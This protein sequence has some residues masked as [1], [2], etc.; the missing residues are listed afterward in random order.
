MNATFDTIHLAA[1]YDQIQTL[2]TELEHLAFTKGLAP[3]R[4]VN[5]S[6]NRPH[7]PQVLFDMRQ[8]VI[9][10]QTKLFRQVV[11]GT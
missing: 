1:L 5:G 4:R 11:Q 8:Q 9:L 7:H 6:F 2:T 3:I 10:P